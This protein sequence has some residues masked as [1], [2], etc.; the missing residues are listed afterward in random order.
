MQLESV[1][2]VTMS[3]FLR[4]TLGQVDDFDSLEGALFDTHAAADAKGLTNEANDR[5]GK[6]LYA[7]LA[8]LINR[9]SFLA[10]LLALLWLA[11]IRVDDGNSEFVFCCFHIR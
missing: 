2:A 10:F 9:A 8:S 6:D 7:Y 4:E 1:G 11:L 5:S 3:N